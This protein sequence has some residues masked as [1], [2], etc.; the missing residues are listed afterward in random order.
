MN[1]AA[2]A[3]LGRA[4]CLVTGVTAL[5]VGLGALHINVLG[6]LHLEGFDTVV[7]YLV[8]F[9]GLTSVVMYLK[10]CSAGKC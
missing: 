7:R 2:K 3:K 4:L 9:A 6:I 1:A 8:G 10:D 5:C